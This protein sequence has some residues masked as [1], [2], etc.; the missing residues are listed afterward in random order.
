MNINYLSA[1]AN[2]EARIVPGRPG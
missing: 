1:A 2:T